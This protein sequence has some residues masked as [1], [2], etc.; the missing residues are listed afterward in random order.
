MFGMRFRRHRQHNTRKLHPAVIAGICLTGAI[1]LTVIVGNLLNL[2]LDDETYK[3]LTDGE[4]ETTP[5]GND[6]KANARKINA[7]PFTLGENI[8][9]VLGIPALSVPINNSNGTLQYTSDVVQHLGLP[10][11][12]AVSLLDTMGE[13]SAYVAYISGTFSP[14]AFV[15]P[16]SDLFYA[17]AV[18][19][20]AVLREFQRAGGS[21]ILLCDLPLTID[22]L[23]QL[24]AYLEAVKSAVKNT[25]V[26][27][28]IPTSVATSD[29]GWEIINTLL[30]TCDFCALDLTAET[31]EDAEPVEGDA[32]PAAL[33]LLSE[34]SYYISQY[35]MR[36]LL[37]NAQETLLS[38]LEFQM[39]PNY[40][41]IYAP[42]LSDQD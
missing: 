22:N 37:S 4:E 31:A 10:C 35:D 28:A 13:L 17:A 15:Q 16:S 30:E 2:W 19:E 23:D 29:D 9:S 14:Q 25:P 33:A 34:Y 40:Q 1:V 8:D 7:Y 27:V 3:K 12:E 36:L 18:Q 26:G 20:A 41:V 11:N 32:S 24:T 38:T 42:S 5:I 39:Y 6:F 21:E